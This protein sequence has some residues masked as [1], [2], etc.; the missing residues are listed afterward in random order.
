MD[1]G[2]LIDTFGYL[3]RRAWRDADRRFA[4]HFRTLDISAVQFSVLE[5]I[6]RNPGCTPGDLVMPMGIT[7]N[8]MVGIIADLVKRGFVTKKTDAHDRRA[9]KLSLTDEGATMLSAAHAVH[10]LYLAEYAQRIGAGNLKD[11]V[12]LLRMFDRG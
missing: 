6:D 7:Q 11:L 12:R 3:L 8:N 10:D 4:H 5:L 1:M 9:R 2:I